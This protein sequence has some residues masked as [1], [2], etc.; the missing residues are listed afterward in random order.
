MCGLISWLCTMTQIYMDEDVH[1][2]KPER[3]RDDIHGRCKHNMGYLPPF[4][5][6][7]RMCIGR[8]LSFLKYKIAL[9][10]PNSV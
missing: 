7:G 5:F 6:G 9:T 3:F 2:F 10:Y 1:E 4:W 8:N